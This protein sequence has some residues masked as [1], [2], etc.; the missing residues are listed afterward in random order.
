MIRPG[1][2]LAVQQTYHVAIDITSRALAALCAA[3][4]SAPDVVV[5]PADAVGS[6]LVL[7]A[8]F[9]D[10]GRA[11]DWNCVQTIW[12]HHPYATPVGIGETA[13]PDLYDEVLSL[14]LAGHGL[15]DAVRVA[16]ADEQGRR[17]EIADP[18]WRSGASG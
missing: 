12:A 15:Q 1:A 5:V 2:H 7:S 13:L 14:P 4:V 6:G 10:A 17:G 16:G 11:D 3:R 8:V 9:A 18:R